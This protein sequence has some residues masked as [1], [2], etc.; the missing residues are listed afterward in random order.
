MKPY[1][2]FKIR[3]KAR[4]LVLQND[5]RASRGFFKDVTCLHERWFKAR[6]ARSANQ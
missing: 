2:A 5:F 4:S 3:R 6:I 1:F